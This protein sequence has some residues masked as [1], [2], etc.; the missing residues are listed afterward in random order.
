MPG[1]N[2]RSK[3]AVGVAL[4]FTF[5]VAALAADMAAA[6]ATPRADLK[7]V[8]GAIPGVKTAVVQGDTATGASHFYLSYAPGLVTPVHHHSPDHYVTTVSGSLVLVVDGKEHRLP[9]GSYFGLT[10]KARHA[11]RCDGSEAC[12]MFIDARSPWDVVPEKKP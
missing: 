1:Q 10:G 5:S 6:V 2:C 11:A 12:V 9:P 8:E 3:V 4:G 7:W